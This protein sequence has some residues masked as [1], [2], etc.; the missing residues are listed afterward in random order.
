MSWFINLLTGM[1]ALLISAAMA[2]FGGE[3]HAA[4]ILSPQPI[5][6]PASQDAAPDNDDA[7]R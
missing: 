7:S 5:S 1:I 2:H 3:S 4:P 6:Q